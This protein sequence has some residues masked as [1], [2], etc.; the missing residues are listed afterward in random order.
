MFCS[1]PRCGNRPSPR[2][3]SLSQP[4]PKVT[5]CAAPTGDLVL[6]ETQIPPVPTLDLTESQSHRQS[7][8]LNLPLDLRDEIFSYVLTTD[9]EVFLGIVAL[10]AQPPNHW[11]PKFTL[12]GEE[13]YRS[14]CL[15][16]LHGS[17]HIP[18]CA[19][20]YPPGDPGLAVELLRVCKQVYSEGARILYSRNAFAIDLCGPNTYERSRRYD[21]SSLE[22]PDIL[23]IH[24]TYH[25]LLRAVSFRLL[26]YENR[27]FAVSFFSLA[28][29]NVL[30]RMPGAYMAFRRRYKYDRIRDTHS[31]D[32]EIFAGWSGSQAPAWCSGRDSPLAHM[33]R[34]L[35][36]SDTQI[37]SGLAYW[38]MGAHWEIPSSG[39]CDLSVLTGL[40]LLD[41][42]VWSDPALHSGPWISED[43]ESRQAA[44]IYLLRLNSDGQAQ[45]RWE[46][47]HEEPERTAIESWFGIPPTSIVGISRGLDLEYQVLPFR[48]PLWKKADHRVLHT[49]RHPASS[50]KRPLCRKLRKWQ[51]ARGA[52]GEPDIFAQNVEGSD[53]IGG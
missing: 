35:V 2:C 40:P 19:H 44:R 51:L 30:R 53:W 14:R 28:M 26:A 22:L 15:C 1:R 4:G 38:N 48:H 18:H 24:P 7:P 6:F 31:V 33:A 45:F 13:C 17:G 23:P 52:K 9:E 29:M 50:I 5:Y 21:K 47:D 49:F 39:H 3:P 46:R 41:L 36:V 42:R 20:G 8:L 16:W 11:H 25:P 12:R 32:S 43:R 37:S 10:E 27:S 34:P